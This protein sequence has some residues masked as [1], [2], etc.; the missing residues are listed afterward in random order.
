M[1]IQHAQKNFLIAPFPQGD[2]GILS[3]ITAV[4]LNP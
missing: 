3:D 1:N 2:I 4:V